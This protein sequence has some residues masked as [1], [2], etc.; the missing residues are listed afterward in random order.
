MNI[1]LGTTADEKDSFAIL[2]R[3][4]E[5]SPQRLRTDYIDVYW[6]ARMDAAC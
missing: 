3:F 5:G 4:A 2:D 6:G 1:A